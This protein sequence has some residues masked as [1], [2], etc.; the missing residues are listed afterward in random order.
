M[1][2][3]CMNITMVSSAQPYRAMM[4]KQLMP[5]HSPDF[6]FDYLIFPTATQVHRIAVPENIL[7]S[8]TH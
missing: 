5:K 6:H 7:S 2:L 3:T 1:A 4:I 8:L